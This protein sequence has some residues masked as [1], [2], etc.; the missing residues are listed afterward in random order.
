MTQV[1]A[2]LAMEIVEYPIIY[3]VLKKPTLYIPSKFSVLP[4]LS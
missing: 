2:P 1:R 3:Y 4:T